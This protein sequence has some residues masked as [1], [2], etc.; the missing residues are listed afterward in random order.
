[1]KRDELVLAVALWLLGRC[2]R[3]GAALPPFQGGGGTFGG[4]GSGGGWQPS[5]GWQP[6]G[7]GYNIPV[8]PL[9]PNPLAK[10]PP[11]GEG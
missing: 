2:K 9:P 6:D 5:P 3:D 10:P 4:S 7:D 8:V 1:M 11:G